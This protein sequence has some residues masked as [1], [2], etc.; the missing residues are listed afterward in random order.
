MRISTVSGLCLLAF[1]SVACAPESESTYYGNSGGTQ[2]GS[3][4]AGVGGTQGGTGATSTGTGS[5]GSG[6]GGGEVTGTGATGTGGG[7]T[8][9]GC[10]GATICDDFE[11]GTLAAHWSI[12]KDSQPAPALDTTRVYGD[13]SQSLKVVGGSQQ[14][15]VIADVPGQDFYVRAYMNF[16]KNTD[17]ISAHGW[18]IVGTD[19]TTSGEA[20]Q[21]RIG[22]SGNHPS[23]K[24]LDFNVY[25]DSCG[26]EKTQFSSG[27]SDGAAGWNNT[28]YTPFKFTADKWYCVEAHFNGP[29]NEL[30]VSIDDTEIQGL[31]VT[32][33]TMC[34]GWSPE[35]K[36]IKIGAGANGDTGAVWY[37]DVVVSTSPIGCD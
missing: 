31:H 9:G 3:G 4:G 34:A 2:S 23:G 29:A 25:G 33:A 22:S 14:S 21:M 35:Y 18:Y 26:G 1:Q 13:G 20:N 28:P 6:G 8:G 10:D 32:E 12:Q 24:Q 17:D 5:V 11:A 37:D 30:T 16:E 19:N 27:A 15:F 7:T 36:Y